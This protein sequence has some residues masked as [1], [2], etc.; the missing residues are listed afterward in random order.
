MTGLV[1]LHLNTLQVHPVNIRITGEPQPTVYAL[2]EIGTS[3]EPKKYINTYRK[4]LVVSASQDILLS[5][6]CLILSCNTL[7]STT[8][9]RMVSWPSLYNRL[10]ETQLPQ[11][12]VKTN[13]KPTLTL[14]S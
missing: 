8:I 2:A 3:N 5:C 7:Q 10:L 11:T 1:L 13:I 14:L 4:K 9:S 6:L 12:V